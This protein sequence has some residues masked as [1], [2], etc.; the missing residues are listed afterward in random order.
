MGSFCLLCALKCRGGPAVPVSH[1]FMVQPRT[2]LCTITP[3]IEIRTVSG[4]DFSIRSYILHHL[5][6][7][8]MY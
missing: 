6:P 2:H 3:R 1:V 8:L 4:G 7:V 5:V